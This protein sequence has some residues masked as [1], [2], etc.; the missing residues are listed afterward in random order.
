VYYLWFTSVEGYILISPKRSITLKFDR[1][2][3]YQE[4][5]NPGKHFWMPKEGSYTAE[6]YFVHSGDRWPSEID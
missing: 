3:F 6:M 1:Y 2:A 5:A 4:D